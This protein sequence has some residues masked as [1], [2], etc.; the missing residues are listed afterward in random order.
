METGEAEAIQPDYYLE[1]MRQNA[2]NL[3][4]GFE[5][6]DQAWRPLWQALRHPRSS[7]LSIPS[8]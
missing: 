4:A 3:A 5:S 2:E 6:A 7:Y 1:T 8:S